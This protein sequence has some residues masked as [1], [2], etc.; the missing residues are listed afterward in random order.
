L[1]RIYFCFHFYFFLFSEINVWTPTYFFWRR[2]TLFF[3]AKNTLVF[4][5]FVQRV[6]FFSSTVFSF[7]FSP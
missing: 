6:F 2:C 4:T 7:H 1:E 3:I 5:L